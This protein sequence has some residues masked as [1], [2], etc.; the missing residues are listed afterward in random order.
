MVTRPVAAGELE[1]APL[2]SGRPAALKR[3]RRDTEIV[4]AEVARRR[5]SDASPPVPVCRDQ[6]A[7]RRT[8]I[9]RPVAR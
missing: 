8:F 2:R 4:H 3:Q 9:G 6:L 7:D 1:G 5:S